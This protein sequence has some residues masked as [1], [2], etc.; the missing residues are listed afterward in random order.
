ML[1]LLRPVSEPF[2]ARLLSWHVGTHLEKPA[3]VRREEKETP[4]SQEVCNRKLARAN[5][6]ARAA[7][8][9]GSIIVQAL[10]TTTQGV[11]HFHLKVVHSSEKKVK[12]RLVSFQA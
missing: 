10:E 1:R 12:E 3:K 7:A 4:P 11:H 8:R 2:D 9:A 6:T 5:V